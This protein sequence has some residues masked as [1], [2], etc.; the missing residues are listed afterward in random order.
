MAFNKAWAA[1]KGGGESAKKT[2][3]GTNILH[4][5]QAEIDLRGSGPEGV[6]PRGPSLFYT[7]MCCV[8]AGL[9]IKYLK[10]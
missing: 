4:T 6:I 9:T 10:E 5:K 8:N 7:R 1:G 2:L 3:M